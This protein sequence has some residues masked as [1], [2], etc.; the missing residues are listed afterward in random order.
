[1]K[2]AEH[3]IHCSQLHIPISGDI[4][5]GTAGFIYRA[6]LF[7]FAFGHE[8]HPGVGPCQLSLAAIP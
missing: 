5:K 6:A 2:Y 8:R 3:V 1:M 4:E 7:C